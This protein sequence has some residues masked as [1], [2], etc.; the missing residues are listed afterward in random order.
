M[1]EFRCQ[2]MEPPNIPDSIVLLPGK[3]D[4]KIPTGDH[5]HRFPRG[6]EQAETPSEEAAPTKTPPRPSKS[7]RA[8]RTLTFT[9]IFQPAGEI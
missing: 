1:R 3:P 6:R 9:A 5:T 7:G 2:V 8:W 4:Y